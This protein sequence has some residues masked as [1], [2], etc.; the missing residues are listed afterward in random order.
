MLHEELDIWSYISNA[1]WAGCVMLYKTAGKEVGLDL[2]GVRAEDWVT[3]IK[4]HCIK[5]SKN[6]KY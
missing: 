5:F 2:E 1:N 6:K 3:M 4:R